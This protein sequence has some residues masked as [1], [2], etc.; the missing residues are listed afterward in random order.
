MV[1]S[2]GIAGALLAARLHDPAGVPDRRPLNAVVAFYI[3]LLVPE[4]LI[5]FF[6]FVAAR[7][8]YRF[9][10]RGDEHIPA[11][12]PAILVSNHVSFVDPYC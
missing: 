8:V 7:L 1:A 2:A 12:G 10:V 4:Y 9:S 6:A 5:R 11:D 3:F